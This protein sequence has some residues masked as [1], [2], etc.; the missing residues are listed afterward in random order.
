MI[1]NGFGGVKVM[2][3]DEYY[4]KIGLRNIKENELLGTLSSSASCIFLGEIERAFLSGGDLWFFSKGYALCVDKWKE[5]WHTDIWDMYLMPLNIQ[6][7]NIKS[8][9]YDFQKQTDSSNL[10]VTVKFK[11]EPLGQQRY[12]KT[13]VARK[14]NCD[15]LKE[16]I[17][18]YLMPKK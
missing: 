7:L 15:D 12:K 10:S 14:A 18:K 11:G 2:K 3:F 13:L 1:R 5:I 6:W 16:I 8:G 17:V 9:G 4:K